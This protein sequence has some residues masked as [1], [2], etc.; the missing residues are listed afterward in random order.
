MTRWNVNFVIGELISELNSSHTYRSSGDVERGVERGVGY[1]GCDFAQ[2]NGAYRI[3]K[4]IQAAPWDS[5]VRSPLARPGLANVSTGDYLL[6][7]NGVPLDPKLDPWAA[8]QG[9]ADKP[10]LLTVNDQ[11]RLKGAR[12]D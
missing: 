8:L 12:E 6:A 7:I 2:T 4:I 10:V 9:L 1:L 11:P 5:E 3:T